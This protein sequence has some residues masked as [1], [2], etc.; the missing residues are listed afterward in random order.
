MIRKVEQPWSDHD[1]YPLVGITIFFYLRYPKHAG[2][3]KWKTGK[4]PSA[5]G[6]ELTVL[7]QLFPNWWKIKVLFHPW[8]KLAFSNTYLLF[9]EE[10]AAGP[11][12]TWKAALICVAVGLLVIAT[13]GGNLLVLLSFRIEKRLQTVSNYFLLSLAVADLMIGKGYADF[14]WP[15][16][17]PELLVQLCGYQGWPCM[18]VLSR[19]W[20]CSTGPHQAKQLQCG[21]KIML[22]RPWPSAESSPF[23]IL[24]MLK[25][26]S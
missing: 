1:P 12:T 4:T 13:V 18:A 8:P 22:Y 16:F 23:V 17:L 3:W 6:S 15:C 14:K 24:I 9:T 21:D 10:P 20:P 5:L 2:K 11:L 26:N 25:D 19:E 7:W